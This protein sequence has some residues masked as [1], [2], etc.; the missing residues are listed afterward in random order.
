MNFFGMIDIT[1]RECLV[2]DDQVQIHT[3]ILKLCIIH[4]SSNLLLTHEHYFFSTFSGV[5][6]EYPEKAR[7]SA[8]VIFYSKQKLKYGIMFKSYCI[9]CFFTANQKRKKSY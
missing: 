9:H 8:F 5:L 2:L 1:L 6:L 3:F 7:S 4:I